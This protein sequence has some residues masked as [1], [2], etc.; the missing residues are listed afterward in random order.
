MEVGHRDIEL[1]IRRTIDVRVADAVLLGDRVA[2][3]D[4]LGI[5]HC[6]KGV[7]V[8]AHSHK[9]AVGGVTKEGE[10][11]GAHILLGEGTLG[12]RRR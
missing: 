8:V 1:T 4:G 9:E 6:G 3:D 5:V 11:I 7:A 2:R 12:F 10:E